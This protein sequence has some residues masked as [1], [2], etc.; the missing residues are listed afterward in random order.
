[1]K[2]MRARVRPR[3]RV[4]L[5]SWSTARDELAEGDDLKSYCRRRADAQVWKP[6]RTPHEHPRAP[7]PGPTPADSE[8][9]TE[10]V[11]AHWRTGLAAAPRRR[12]GRLNRFLNAKTPNVRFSFLA[13]PRAHPNRA[14]RPA[15]VRLERQA[16]VAVVAGRLLAQARRHHRRG[17][18]EAHDRGDQGKPEEGRSAA[19]RSEGRHLRAG[20]VRQARKLLHRRADDAI[21]ASRQR[22]RKLRFS[23][24]WT[25][26][27]SLRWTSKAGAF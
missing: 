14:D 24:N 26:G 27:A 2:W 19:R 16:P 21:T 3:L 11:S 5:R 6:S 12:G 23:G 20:P 9:D 8:N 4:C 25:T 22:R 15:R 18:M 1:M 10:R 13:Y 17:R 7:A